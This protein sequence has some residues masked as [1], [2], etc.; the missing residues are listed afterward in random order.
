MRSASACSGNSTSRR[1]ESHAFLSVTDAQAEIHPVPQVSVCQVFREVTLELLVDE[2]A[3]PRLQD[4]ACAMQER[5][6][7][8]ACSSRRQPCSQRSPAVAL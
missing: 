7:R 2:S 1:Y 6:Y 3:K 5:D 4:E 8:Q